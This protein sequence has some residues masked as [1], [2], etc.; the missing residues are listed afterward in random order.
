V[1]RRGN[2]RPVK[3]R[4]TP[5]VSK[6]KGGRGGGAVGRR[7]LGGGTEGHGVAL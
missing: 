2:G 4:L 1:E 5:M 3:W 7:Q 6:L